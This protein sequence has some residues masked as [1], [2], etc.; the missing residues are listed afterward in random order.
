[1][2]YYNGRGRA[3]NI[4]I[5]FE[6]AKQEYEDYRFPTNADNETDPS[7]AN[8]AY[9]ALAPSLPFGQ[10]PVLEIGEGDKKFV[11]AQTRAIQRYVANKL[12]LV[13]SCSFAAAFADSVVEGLHDLFTEMLKVFF[14]PKEKMEEAKKDFVD[15]HLPVF[16]EQFTKILRNFGTG[17]YG[18]KFCY[19]DIDGYVLWDAINRIFG[20]AFEL[21]PDIRAHCELIS[22]RPN[23]SAWVKRRPQTPF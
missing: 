8:D 22:S 16:G 4:R 17:F 12:G 6:E 1:L 19:A 15:N 11:L 3:E 7:R 21:F 18:K 13:P 10:V 9:T 5:Y 20:K 14:V 23:I 2:I